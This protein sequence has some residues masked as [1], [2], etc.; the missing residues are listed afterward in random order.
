M[1][2][3]VVPLV[4]Q[5]GLTVGVNEYTGVTP[6][7][8]GSGSLDKKRHESLIETLESS[9]SDPYSGS[10][11]LVWQ[12]APRPKVPFNLTLFAITLN[13]INDNLRPWLP[14]TDTRLRP[15]QR[16]MEDGRYDEASKE[17]HRVE[18]KQRAARKR[19]EA[20]REVYKPNWFVKLKHPVTGDAYWKF[21]GDYWRKRSRKELAGTG[22]IF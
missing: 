19:R 21:K 1:P 2:L 11:F 18:E 13:E 16:A 3:V 15:D 20:N 4:E 17:K 8:S 12:A 5:V 22:D 7:I 9:S 10:K 14:P 6:E